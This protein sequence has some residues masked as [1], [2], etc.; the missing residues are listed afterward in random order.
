MIFFFFNCFKNYNTGSEDNFDAKND[1]NINIKLIWLKIS[2]KYTVYY[3]Q[4]RQVNQ[5]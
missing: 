2:D 5:Q 4:K 3:I 1:H